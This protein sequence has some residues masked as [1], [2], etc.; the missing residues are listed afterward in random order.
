MDAQ[1]KKLTCNQMFTKDDNSIV[2][3]MTDPTLTKLQ[4][5]LNVGF[6][7]KSGIAVILNDTAAQCV[8]ISEVRTNANNF[9]TKADSPYFCD[10]NKTYSTP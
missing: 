8:Q 9:A 3:F 2:G 1:S 5:S 6:F 7:C 10:L 4:N